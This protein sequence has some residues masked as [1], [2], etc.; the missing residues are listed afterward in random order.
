MKCKFLSAFEPMKRDTENNDGRPEVCH[1]K[2]YYVYEFSLSLFLTRSLRLP[3]SCL[4]LFLRVFILFASFANLHDLYAYVAPHTPVA[5][6][7]LRIMWSSSRFTIV[8][9]PRKDG[10]RELGPG[11]IYTCIYHSAGP[12]VTAYD[13]TGKIMRSTA[14]EIPITS[15]IQFTMQLYCRATGR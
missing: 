7:V 15:S 1:L 10:S 4:F 14:L 2:I 11:K 8:L 6:Y 12:W 9:W 13:T 5:R 3:Q